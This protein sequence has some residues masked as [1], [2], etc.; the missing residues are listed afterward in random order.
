MTLCLSISFVIDLVTAALDL[1]YRIGLLPIL[2]YSNIALN[3]SLT[4]SVSYTVSSIW[5]V[6][7]RELSIVAVL[8]LLVSILLDD[9]IFLILLAKPNKSIFLGI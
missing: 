6:S 4:A 2:F 8:L 9:S 5:T 7:V 3:L 1:H